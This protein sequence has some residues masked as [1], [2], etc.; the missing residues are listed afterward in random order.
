MISIVAVKHDFAKV[1]RGSVVIFDADSGLCLLKEIWITI[2]SSALIG[3]LMSLSKLLLFSK[4][5]HFNSNGGTE[6]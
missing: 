4:E 6:N 5:V 3:M 1:D 2:L